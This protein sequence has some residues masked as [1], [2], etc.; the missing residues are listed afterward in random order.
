MTRWNFTGGFRFHRGHGA[1]MGP[2]PTQQCQRITLCLASGEW[3]PQ[4]ISAARQD[5]KVVTLKVNPKT[6]GLFEGNVK[7]TYLKK[8]QKA[9][10]G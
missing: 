4:P 2:D 3:T 1:G 8:C 6:T 9:D 10:R 5:E 7:I